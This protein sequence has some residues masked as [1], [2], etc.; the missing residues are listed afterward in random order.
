MLSGDVD[1]GDDVLYEASWVILYKCLHV[2]LCVVF[3]SIRNFLSSLCYGVMFLI[4]W[5]PVPVLWG[6]WSFTCSLFPVNLIAPSYLLPSTLLLFYYSTD[7]IFRVDSFLPSLP[8]HEDALG[9]K[10]CIWLISGLLIRCCKFSKLL[11]E[12]GWKFDFLVSLSPFALWVGPACVVITK[13]L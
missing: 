8:N 5:G 7:T 6:L 3:F 9:Q 13:E 4:L 1:E 11:P 12:L 2:P 10:V